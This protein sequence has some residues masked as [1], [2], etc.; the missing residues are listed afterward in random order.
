M[1]ENLMSRSAKVILS[2][3]KG[4]NTI[5]RKLLHL[6]MILTTERNIVKSIGET[7]MYVTAVE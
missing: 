4:D 2:I 6:Y 5:G 3:S 7:R 1:C